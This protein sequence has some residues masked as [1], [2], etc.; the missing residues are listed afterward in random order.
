MIE[1]PPVKLLDGILA[2]QSDSEMPLHAQVRRALTCLIDD[3]FEHGQRFWTE[4]ILIEQLKVSQITVRRALTDLTKAGVLDR[5]IAKGTFVC[6]MSP[7][8]AAVSTIGVFVPQYNSAFLHEFLE[9]VAIACWHINVRLRIYHTQ[10]G[11]R[12]ADVLRQLETP[13]SEERLLIVNPA[14]TATALLRTLQEKKYQYVLVDTPL[15]GDTHAY[16]G[17]DNVAGIEMGMRYLMDLGHRRILFIVNEPEEAETVKI[18]LATFE[19]I[20]ADAGLIESGVFHC[21]VKYWE[22]SY[23][24]AFLRMPDI[25]Q[26]TPHYTAIL[27]ASDPGAWAAVNW[28]SERGIRVPDEL[29]VL[30]FGDESPSRFTQPAL[31]SIAHQIAD[32]AQRAVDIALSGEQ[33]Q[34]L[35]PPALIIRQS[36]GP[37]PA[38][39]KQ[40]VVAAKEK[41]EQSHVCS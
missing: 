28:L 41:K 29:S 1:P 25:M 15:P 23:D 24:A 3:H 20:V 39:E 30:G 22:D 8:P 7:A 37:V 26:Q 31:S 34:A 14:H 17:T 40:S 12:T 5:R 10:R 9:H 16:V 19:R 36:T 18:R 2:D 32:L 21:G 27:A 11:A 6:K 33:I 38:I 4:S 13:S 35:L